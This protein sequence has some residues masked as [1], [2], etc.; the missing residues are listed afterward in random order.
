M[1]YEIIIKGY[2]TDSMANHFKPF[3]IEFL[4]SGFTRLTG[5]ISDQASLYGLL[6]RIRDL[7]IELVKLKKKMDVKI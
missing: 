2:L 4:D 6:N 7:N 1:T 5:Y 3:Q